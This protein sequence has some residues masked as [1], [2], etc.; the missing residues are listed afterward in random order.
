[1]HRGD[2]I[3]KHPRRVAQTV[4]VVVGKHHD[5]AH[6]GTRATSSDGGRRRN[7]EVTRR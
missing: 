1:M 5:R 7:E 4:A 6:A 2:V 3:E